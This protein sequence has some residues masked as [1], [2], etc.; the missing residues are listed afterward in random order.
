VAD[1]AGSVVDSLPD[2]GNVS[3]DPGDVPVGPVIALEFVNGYGA[4]TDPDV[5]ADDGVALG[6]PD[7]SLD[8]ALALA[9]GEGTTVEF[10]G[11]VTDNPDIVPEPAVTLGPVAVEFDNG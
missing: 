6:D 5:S 4:G 3:L 10:C 11:L 8:E 1:C 9:V 7:S 2:I